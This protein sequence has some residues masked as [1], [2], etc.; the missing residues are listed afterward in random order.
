MYLIKS[1]HHAH[2]LRRLFRAATA[3]T[4][5]LLIVTVILWGLAGLG[6]F[7]LERYGK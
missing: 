7:F 2:P 1:T 5:V 6:T 4:G 3:A